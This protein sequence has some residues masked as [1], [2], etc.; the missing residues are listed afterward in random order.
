[1][2]SSGRSSIPAVCTDYRLKK[3]I[4]TSKILVKP[5]DFIIKHYTN[6]IHMYVKI[7]KKFFLIHS[8]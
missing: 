1:M 8:F 3:Q 6:I 5:L 2:I 4:F 7:V